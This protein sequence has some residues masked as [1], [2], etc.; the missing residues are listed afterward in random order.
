MENGSEQ[1][2][3]RV[4]RL[5]TLDK[6]F[7]ALPGSARKIV[8]QK[9]IVKTINIPRYAQNIKIAF[10]ASHCIVVLTY[11]IVILYSNTQRFFFQGRHT[12]GLSSKNNT[13]C[14]IY[15]INRK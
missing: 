1:N 3:R 14:I 12:L 9:K 10:N 2:A 13:S 4:Y 6:I 15:I 8:D 7:R 5:W 11:N